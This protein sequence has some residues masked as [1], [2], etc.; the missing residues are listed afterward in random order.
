MIQI[1]E[2]H[3]HEAGGTACRKKGELHHPLSHMLTAEAIARIPGA[4]S[5]DALKHCLIAY[6]LV[7]CRKNVSEAAR[8]LGMDRGTIHRLVRQKDHLPLSSHIRH[9]Q[10]A[11]LLTDPPIT[12]AKLEEC[13]I[14]YA[15]A[16][17]GQA[18]QAAKHLR[19]DRRTLYRSMD[20][21]GIPSPA[22]LRRQQQVL[23]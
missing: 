2:R 20:R 7:R 3:S 9:A 14:R 11:D 17:A 10:P 6:A 5:L 16:E 1:S 18:T 4:V 21:L 15:L 13:A 22:A 23:A 19:L 12:R 8:V